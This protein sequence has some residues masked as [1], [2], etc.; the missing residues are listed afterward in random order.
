MKNIFEELGTTKLDR[1]YYES[2]VE[3][4]GIKKVQEML[5]QGIAIKSQ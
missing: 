1:R 2:E 5:E 4:P 3:Q